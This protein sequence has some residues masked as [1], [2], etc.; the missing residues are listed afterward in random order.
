MSRNCSRWGHAREVI[1]HLGSVA[2]ERRVVRHHGGHVARLKPQLILAVFARNDHDRADVAE[3]AGDALLENRIVL[4][5]PALLL[6]AGRPPHD[7]IVGLVR[8]G[9]VNV[10]DAGVLAEVRADVAAAVDDAQ[11]MSRDERAPKL[12]RETA[13][14]IR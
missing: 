5:A 7:A 3:L 11:K 2:V 4:A 14:P 8:S 12:A 1:K 13:P 9:D 10:V 6:G